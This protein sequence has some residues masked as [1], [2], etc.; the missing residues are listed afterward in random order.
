MMKTKYIGYIFTF[1]FNAFV[2]QFQT[3]QSVEC[4]NKSSKLQCHENKTI[5]INYV[6]WYSWQSKC[7]SAFEGNCNTGRKLIEEKCNSNKTCTLVGNDF[8]SCSKQHRHVDVKVYCTGWWP[9]SHYTY[10]KHVEVCGSLAEMYCGYYYAISKIDILKIE[11]IDECE[12]GREV[13]NCITKTFR[14]CIGYRSCG[15]IRLNNRKCFYLAPRSIIDYSCKEETT[16]LSTTTVNNRNHGIIPTA[17][18]PQ[19]TIAVDITK[20]PKSDKIEWILD[21]DKDARLL[22][23]NK[24]RNLTYSLCANNWTNEYAIIVCRHLKRSDNGIAGVIPRNSNLSRIAYGLDC[25]VNITNP[26]ECKP[27]NTNAS[28]KICNF[29]GDASVRCYNDTDSHF[30]VKTGIIVG[31]ILGFVFVL[32]IIV[33]FILCRRRKNKKVNKRTGYETRENTS[34]YDKPSNMNNQSAT[35]NYHRENDMHDTGEQER[36]TLTIPTTPEAATQLDGG[37]Y[38]VLDPGA[39]GFNR[40]NTN[41]SEK[42]NETQYATSSDGVYDVTNE[43]RHI[44][45]DEINIYSHTVDDVYDTSANDRRGKERDNSYDDCVI[46]NDG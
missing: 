35:A 1:V 29:T 23:I 19:R 17:D 13:S 10:T 7:R 41:Y 28:R 45:K 34:A 38:F 8:N 37:Q 12:V 21:L 2:P 40:S 3:D 9:Y 33:V 31:G 43:R 5:D 6:V 36:V 39:T 26:F 32:V 46:Q 16:G 25:P 4:G 18:V 27:D 11:F 44:E 42:D 24:K 14:R 20:P 30:S 22:V 15:N